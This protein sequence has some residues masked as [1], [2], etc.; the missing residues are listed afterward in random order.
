MNYTLNQLIIFLKVVETG[1]ITKASEQ[2]HLTQPAVSIQ[3]KNFQDQ[4]DIPLT[5]LIGRKVFITEFGHEIAQSAERIMNE[6]A[7]INQKTLDFKGMLVGKLSLSVVSTGKYILPYFL[8]S[9]VNKNPGINLNI[10]VTNKNLVIDSLSNNEIDF[11]LVSGIPEKLK[12]KKLDLMEN[13]LFLIG[14]NEDPSNK[15]QL[16]PGDFSKLPLI[17]REQGSGT[18]EIM[19]Q[20]FEKKKILPSKRLELF[21]NE[22]VKQA[23]LAG[24][25][26]S[27]MP[28]IGLKN[29]IELSQ[30][31]IL[32]AAD[33]PITSV[34]SLI[35]LEDKKLSP[36]AMAFI[37]FMEENKTTLINNHFKWY[38]SFASA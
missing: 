29:E 36:V 23:I 4:F 9:F 19:E 22:A 30:V 17:F 34:W 3:L 20:F 35:W 33:L 8:E 2:L 31:Y 13:K 7:E 27:I 12:I 21:S 26:Y 16:Q 14:K 1:S 25:G 10:S 32:P 11:A 18:R 38:T 5:E 28:L 6:V 15:S 24:L 37:K